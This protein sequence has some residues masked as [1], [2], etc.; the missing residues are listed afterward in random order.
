MKKNQ[1][2][3]D[4]D[5]QSSQVSQLTDQLIILFLS[6]FLSLFLTFWDDWAQRLV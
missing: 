4:L 6:F 3:G 1:L 5:C 2:T